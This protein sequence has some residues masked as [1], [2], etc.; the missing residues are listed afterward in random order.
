MKKT[1]LDKNLREAILPPP[2]LQN[3][4]NND[5]ASLTSSKEPIRIKTKSH[6][7]LFSCLHSNHCQDLLVDS[8]YQ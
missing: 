5:L 6:D 2:I 3:L 4:I 8:H 1:D 7:S